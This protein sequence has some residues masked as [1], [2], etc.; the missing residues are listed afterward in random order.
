M[1][2]AS[3]VTY[4]RREAL[5][6]RASLTRKGQMTHSS[7]MNPADASRAATAVLDAVE[8]ALV[9]KRESLE[10]VLA[11]ILAGGHVLLEDLPGLGK[12]LAAQIGRAS[13]RARAESDGAGVAVHVPQV[14]A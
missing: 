2:H 5:P 14:A 4:S 8:T 11:G 7:P 9:G 13:C 6:P 1:P 12:T 3:G 10:L